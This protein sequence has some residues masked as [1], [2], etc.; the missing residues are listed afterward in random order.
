[1]QRPGE[2]VPQAQDLVFADGPAGAPP[3][4][5]LLQLGKKPPLTSLRSSQLEARTRMRR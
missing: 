5:E 4:P 3:G 2:R 1:M